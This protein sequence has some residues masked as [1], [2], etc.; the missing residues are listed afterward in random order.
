VVVG[1]P[2]PELAWAAVRM[3]RRL[4]VPVL[5]YLQDLWPDA[6]KTTLR[7]RSVFLQAA[8]RLYQFLCRD[9]LRG[10]NALIAITNEYLEWAATKLKPLRRPPGIVVPLAYALPSF[11]DEE[12]ARADEWG[13]GA[14]SGR[15]G[16]GLRVGFVGSLSR[17]F[18]LQTVFDAL[19]RANRDGR[20]IQL[21][22]AGAGDEESHLRKA[23]VD[24]PNVVWLGWLDWARVWWLLRNVDVGI[25]PYVSHP[26]FDWNVP[27]KIVEYLAAGLPIL[28]CLSGPAANLI[29]AH[30]CGARYDA[31]DVDGLYQRL[32]WF[33]EH[34]DDRRAMARNA[35][36]VYD[37]LFR[38]EVCYRPV[39]SFLEDL[40]VR[41]RGRSLGG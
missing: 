20:A 16:G 31:G 10:A 23:S 3:G 37:R 21:L 2:P 19:R 7:G 9:S 5:L 40:A 36:A 32:C 26:N 18:D 33:G 25:A 39:V 30:K 13:R 17:A 27:N 8:A 22:I 41:G 38:P 6:W 15:P 12:L 29:L 24:L 4:G 28:T 1:Y 34:P 14:I 11:S 35:R